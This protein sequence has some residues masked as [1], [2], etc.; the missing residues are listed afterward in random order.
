MTGPKQGRVTPRFVPFH[1]AVPPN[2]TRRR[3]RGLWIKRVPRRDH[4]TRSIEPLAAYLSEDLVQT[5]R[6]P[7]IM[8][9]SL[10]LKILPAIVHRVER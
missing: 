9:F 5:L 8:C 1:D 10:Q 4:V 3:L 6:L 7:P 2:R